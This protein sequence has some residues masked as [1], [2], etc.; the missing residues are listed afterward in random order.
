MLQWLTRI[1]PWKHREE[2]RPEDDT[3]YEAGEKIDA[4]DKSV[5]RSDISHELHV[6]CGEKLSMLHSF[7]V[8]RLGTQRILQK[9]DKRIHE[10]LAD[11][12]T[13][14]LFQSGATITKQGDLG[15]GAFFI[16]IGSV[17]VVVNG[18]HIATR[19]AK[20]CV[21]EMSLLDPAQK[22]SATLI[23]QEDSHLLRIDEKTFSALLSEPQVLKNIAIELADRLRER[24]RGVPRPNE[25][26]SI[27]VGS[28]SEHLSIAKNLGK[29]LRRNNLFTVKAWD[30]GVFELSKSNLESLLEIAKTSDFGVFVLSPDDVVTSRDTTS[31]AP[32]DNVLFELGMFMGQLG[33]ERTFIIL[34]GDNIK[35]PSDMNGVVFYPLT[36]PKGK[37]KRIA[38]CAQRLEQEIKK[39]W[40]K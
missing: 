14:L 9:C 12:G 18:K 22:R 37:K 28:S 5:L 25:K 35:L 30:E 3:R 29:Q 33:R 13:A 6:E 24:A 39:K 40:V 26:P 31:N 1:W 20:E 17:K 10:R 27:F 7:L 21:G 23:A 19:Y 15:N 8:N 2:T 32:R 38:A 4:S 34:C 16:L 36:T 11:K